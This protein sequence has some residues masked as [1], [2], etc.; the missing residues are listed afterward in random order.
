MF[1]KPNPKYIFTNCSTADMLSSAEGRRQHTFII[2][3]YQHL[4]KK[5]SPNV[6]FFSRNYDFKLTM[7]SKEN[8]L[9]VILVLLF[10]PN[11]LPYQHAWLL[12][13]FV[14][15]LVALTLLEDVGRKHLSEHYM[16]VNRIWYASGF[17]MPVM[18]CLPSC[19]QEH[20]NAVYSGSG[21]EVNSIQMWQRE[22]INPSGL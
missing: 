3:L 19:V 9:A 22:K 18:L 15:L 8:L 4:W 6:V 20:K 17:I 7:E 5:S 11:P 21:L 1:L 2:N 13:L 16:Y 12:C 14:R 10:V